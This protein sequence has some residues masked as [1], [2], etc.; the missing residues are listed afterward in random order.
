MLYTLAGPPGEQGSE[1]RESTYPSCSRS[2]QVKVQKGRLVAA[3]TH[4]HHAAP[5]HHRT[6]PGTQEARVGSIT[7]FTGYIALAH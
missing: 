7:P 4:A 5:E 2:L 3:I 6:A 1:A